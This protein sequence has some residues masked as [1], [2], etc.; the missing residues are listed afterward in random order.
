M[1]ACTVLNGASE[2]GTGS[3]DWL[4]FGI[5][6]TLPKSRTGSRSKAEKVKLNVN[7]ARRLLTKL[8]ILQKP[9]LRRS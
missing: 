4:F 8:S 3:V 5:L 2:T 6:A 1:S 7:V 9:K